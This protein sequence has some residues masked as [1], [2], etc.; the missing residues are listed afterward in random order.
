VEW[1][2][3]S[4]GDGGT[5][6]LAKNAEDDSHLFLCANYSKRLTFEKVR[7]DVAKVAAQPP[8]K[9]KCVTIIAGAKVSAK[10]RKKAKTE[11]ISKL[12]IKES[13]VWSGPEFEERLRA[14]AQDLLQRF[15][16]GDPFP[17]QPED[18]RLLAA[19]SVEDAI[20]ADAKRI[21]ALD[22]R[23]RVSL[24]VINSA[25][26]YKLLPKENITGLLKVS[27]PNVAKMQ[28]LFDYGKPTTLEGG[29]VDLDGVPLIGQLIKNKGS[30]Q[31]LSIQPTKPSKVEFHFWA[32]GP[33]GFRFTIPGQISGGQKGVIFQSKLSSGAPLKAEMKMLRSELTLPTGK[34]SLSLKFAFD[35]WEGKPLLTLPYFDRIRS[36]SSAIVRK[37]LIHHEITVDGNRIAG[38]TLGTPSDSDPFEFAAAVIES[39]ARARE[40]AIRLQLK[41][42]VPNLNNL[43][44]ESFEEVDLAHAFL[45]G[46][47]VCRKGLGFRI[48]ITLSSAKR[49]AS[50][51]ITDLENCCAQGDFSFTKRGQ[52]V[53]IYG[54]PV[55]IG[56]VTYSA[57]K[58]RLVVPE[59]GRSDFLMGEAKEVQ[60]TIEALS[61][62]EVSISVAPSSVD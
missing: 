9:L 23:W 17:E 34:G 41:L 43:S 31:S 33:E 40:I 28:D 56:D 29:A 2:G 35:E 55:S 54:T 46:N 48:D 22:S 39:V 60:A 58:V 15:V 12:Q 6:I 57:T 1:L 36:F 5:D 4:G 52:T 62:S 44:L 51:V 11:V 49:A 10:L 30:I 20:L 61:D 18:L 14:G 16:R 37:K 47:V 59:P 26:H 7:K 45:F 25:K 13:E 32:D 50:E 42:V 3:Q 27:G 21:E 8:T 19:S 53:R 24:D 38:G